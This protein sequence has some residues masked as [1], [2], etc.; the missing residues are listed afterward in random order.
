[1][2]KTKTAVPVN[3][4]SVTGFLPRGCGSAPIAGGT[5]ASVD[6]KQ[7][8]AWKFALC[9]TVAI[10]DEFGLSPI[11]MMLYE[12]I[13]YRTGKSVFDIYDWI[14]EGGYPNPVDWLMEVQNL[15]FHQKMNP[16]DLTKLT[17]ESMYYA[18]HSRASYVDPTEA[19]ASRLVMEGVPKCPANHEAHLQYGDESKQDWDTCAGLLISNIVGGEKI[20]DREVERTMPAFKYRGF[21]PAGCEGE[22]RPGV[23]FALPI[24]IM[25]RFLVYEDKQENAHED[26]LKI[27]EELDEKLQRVTV[28]KWE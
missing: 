6:F 24:G 8:S 10:P 23:F 9:P 27:L 28:V 4:Q 11:S 20:H 3:T 18:V 17:R 25:A 16:H 26:A 1:M 14:G 22:T 13:D 15:G 7:I 21:S 5:Y 19:F 2:S 12:R